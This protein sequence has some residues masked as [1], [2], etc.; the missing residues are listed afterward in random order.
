MNAIVNVRT[1][2][3]MEVQIEISAFQ[4]EQS[5]TIYG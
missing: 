3:Q 4:N 5:K 2:T 1:W